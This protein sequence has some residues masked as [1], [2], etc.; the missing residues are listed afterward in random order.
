MQFFLQCQRQYSKGK[1]KDL[2][3][4]YKYRFTWNKIGINLDM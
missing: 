3:A 2:S 1:K 4:S